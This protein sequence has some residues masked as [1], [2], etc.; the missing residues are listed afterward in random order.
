MQ[1][2]QITATHPEYRFET[3]EV[4]RPAAGRT[5]LLVRVAATGLNPAGW[6]FAGTD[7]APLPH[8]V[9]LDVAGTVVEVGSEVEGFAVGDRVVGQAPMRT[10]TFAEYAV[11]RARSTAR[12][13]DAVSFTDAATLPTSGQTAWAAMVEEGH[14]QPGQTVLIHGAG[15]AVGTFAVQIARNSGARVIATASARHH[16]MLRGLGAERIIDYTTA[17]FWEEIG[18]VDL[19]LDPI[20]GETFHRSIDVLRNGGTIVTIAFFGDPP[21][22]M[23]EQQNLRVR[24]LSMR[25]D[26][27]RLRTL[28]S[29]VA[30]GAI[31]PV[32]G[33]LAPL[34]EAVETVRGSML[35]HNQ[36]NIV[37]TVP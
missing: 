26:R 15:G 37:I 2:L 34:S 36:G 33:T 16:A 10:G 17:R 25:P 27:E 35:G 21:G 18:D 1:Q 8:P 13:P 14:V 23:V 28:V 20:G 19:A 12:L 31:R 6:K 22:N 7:T 30:A 32:I 4:E 9:G 29:L 11:T 3:V 5:R 24:Q